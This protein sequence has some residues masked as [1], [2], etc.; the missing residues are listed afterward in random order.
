[1]FCHCAL[2][3]SSAALC[4]CGHIWRAQAGT[5]RPVIQAWQLVPTGTRMHGPGSPQRRP[6]CM[7]AYSPMHATA[8]CT[9]PWLRLKHHTSPSAAQLPPCRTIVPLLPA[10]TLLPLLLLLLLVEAGTIRHPRSSAQAQIQC[11]QKTRSHTQPTRPAAAAACLLPQNSRVGQ[12]TVAIL[13]YIKKH[14]RHF[15]QTT[16]SGVPERLLRCALHAGLGRA[17]CWGAAAA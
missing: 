12:A 2:P 16:G 14:Q 6:A 3:L 15:L 11:Q 4:P 8:C 7:H 13:E 17:P 10:A 1:M 5:A 9:K